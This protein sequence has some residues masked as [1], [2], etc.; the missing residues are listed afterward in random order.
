MV[1]NFYLSD[2]IRQCWQYAPVPSLSDFPTTYN[3]Q[4]GFNHS[5][6]NLAEC[7]QITQVS[8][9]AQE[10]RTCGAK[11]YDEDRER[12]NKTTHKVRGERKVCRKCASLQL[13]RLWV[14]VLKKL[15]RNGPF[16]A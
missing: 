8:M 13:L 12:L 1:V 10:I 14:S 11:T 6:F 15:H 9:M 4:G 5:E 7:F 2:S 16:Y 3:A